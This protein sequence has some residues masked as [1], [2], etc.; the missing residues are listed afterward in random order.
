[1]KGCALSR[2]N[3]G[4]ELR[5]LSSESILYMREPPRAQCPDTYVKPKT[6]WAYTLNEL[7]TSPLLRDID[8]A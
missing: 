4:V 2:A 3:T 1:M 5:E 7:L 6:D 8:P